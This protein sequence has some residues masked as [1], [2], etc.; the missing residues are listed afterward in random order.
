MNKED[1]NSYKDSGI[2]KLM[3]MKFQINKS[4]EVLINKAT[5]L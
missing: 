2:C 5:R 4:E 3:S 1:S